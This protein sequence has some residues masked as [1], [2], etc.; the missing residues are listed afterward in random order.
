MR[1]NFDKTERASNEKNKDVQKQKTSCVVRVFKN[2][3][4]LP[5]ARNDPSYASE[6]QGLPPRRSRDLCPPE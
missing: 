3:Q 1:S 2:G 6:G 4:G 5:R